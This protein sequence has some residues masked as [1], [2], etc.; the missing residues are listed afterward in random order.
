MKTH[1]ERQFV[2]WA[3]SHNMGL[4]EAYP[5]SAVLTFTPDP[6]LAR[7]WE[8]P[9]EPERRSYFLWLMLELM[10]DWKT[11]FV[12]RHLGSWPSPADP[13]RVNDQVEFCILDGLG[14]PMGTTD[15]I[16]F[17]QSESDRLVTLLFSTTVFGWSVA[18][19]LYVVPDHAHYIMK[20]DHHD[21]VHVSFRDEASLQKF[22][23][24]MQEEDFVLPDRLP[25]PT[26]RTPKWMEK[27]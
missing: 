16:E 12:W 3:I 24:G 1:T 13:Q 26:F 9:P 27:E 4:D 15:I 23:T 25:D 10:V 21:V 6:D 22:V 18:E 7:F 5:D 17:N 11:C 2:K 8:I 20:T 14:L 19:D